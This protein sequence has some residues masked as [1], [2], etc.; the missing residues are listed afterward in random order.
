MNARYQIEKCGTYYNRQ[1]VTQ[2]QNQN[3]ENLDNN[4]ELNDRLNTSP[5]LSIAFMN[6]YYTRESRQNI[7][8]ESQIPINTVANQIDNTNSLLKK[9]D[10]DDLIS[11]VPEFCAMTTFQRTKSVFEGYNATKLYIYND[12][13]KTCVAFDQLEDIPKYFTCD[14][15]DIKGIKSCIPLSPV[16]RSCNSPNF[17]TA[18]ASFKNNDDY[19]TTRAFKLYD[20]NVHITSDFYIGC[21]KEFHIYQINNYTYLLKSHRFQRRQFL[22][23][24]YYLILQ[25]ID[26]E[27]VEN[28][29]WKPEH[30]CDVYLAVEILDLIKVYK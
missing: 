12:L 2:N 23:G 14:S 6:A 20:T 24:I 11:C 13:V 27:V 10:F 30:I 16:E 5:V 7:I 1:S 4:Q 28:H 17:S 15:L 9:R 18:V 19:S 25:N 8:M 26:S 22:L 3:A 21:F 29:E